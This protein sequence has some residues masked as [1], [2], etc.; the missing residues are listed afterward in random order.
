[1]LVVLLLLILLPDAELQ[2][3]RKAAW[4]LG[5]RRL[6]ADVYMRVYTKR[7]HLAVPES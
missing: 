2:G 4:M 7:S 6:G 5:F 1:M 3:R